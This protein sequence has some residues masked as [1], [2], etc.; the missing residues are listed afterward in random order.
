VFKDAKI[1]E[2]EAETRRLE[3]LTR[4]DAPELD[5]RAAYDGLE[6]EI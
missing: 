3:S 6:I 2:I 5:I 1:A 4:Q